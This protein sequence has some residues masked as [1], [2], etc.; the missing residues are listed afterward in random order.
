MAQGGVVPSGMELKPAACSDCCSPGSE[1]LSDR[2]L[3]VLRLMASG[4]SNVPF[5]RS[6][7]F[8]S[9]PSRPTATTSTANSPGSA[10]RR[11]LRER[12]P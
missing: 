11:P 3:A 2:A 7:W 9:A 1:P 5:L 12:V 4:R 6:W 8:R 10:A